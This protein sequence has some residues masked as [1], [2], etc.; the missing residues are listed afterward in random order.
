MALHDAFSGHWLASAP[1]LQMSAQL[2]GDWLPCDSRTHLG[3]AWVPV[4]TSVGH[5]AVGLQFGE[6]KLPESP[7]I[8]IAS[9]SDKHFPPLAFGSS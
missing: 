5:G 9:S 4:G 6:Q 7:V 3:C 8:W 2:V 1:G